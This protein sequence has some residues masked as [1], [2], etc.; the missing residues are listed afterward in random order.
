NAI[1]YL[2]ITI[3]CF[4]LFFFSFLSLNIIGG[5]AEQVISNFFNS[6]LDS[7]YYLYFIKTFIS[8]DPVVVLNNNS[9]LSLSN[10]FPFLNLRSYGSKVDSAF[11]L[12]S[13]PARKLFNDSP[14][15]QFGPIPEPVKKYYNL[16]MSK[17]T[18]LIEKELYG[19]S[20]I[21]ALENNLD[22]KIYI[23]SANDLSVRLKQHINP[24]SGKSNLR[25][26]R[27]IKKHG[28]DN[29]NFIVYEFYDAPF[30][31]PSPLRLL[32]LKNNKITLTELETIY[33]Q[34]FHA[35]SVYNIKRIADSLSGYKHN[36]RSLKKMR[37]R[38]LTLAHP[39]LGKT[40]SLRAIAKISARSRG[41]KNPRFGFKLTNETKSLMS[42]KKKIPLYLYDLNKNLIRS[43]E[44]GLEAAV[45]FKVHKATISKYLKPGKI[46]QG[47]YILTREQKIN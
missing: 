37:D 20:G 40:H 16:S 23:G 47:K 9:C 34:S 25:L 29:L 26:Q 39:M 17:I 11:D 8:F 3:V 24:L 14:Q 19:K 38:Y 45:F 22:K 4:Y 33:I 31:H 44:S 28:L 6:L 7:L 1:N 12:N 32:Q 21:Y 10:L 46:I 5:A 36:L 13:K 27:A 18:D 42:E 15:K 41:A 2:V 35:S 43:F 30:R